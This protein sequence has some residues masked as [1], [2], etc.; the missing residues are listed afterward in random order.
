MYSISS[1]K[2]LL[3]LIFLSLFFVDNYKALSEN[4]LFF[5][6]QPKI[7]SNRKNFIKKSYYELLN[8]KKSDDCLNDLLY[9]NNIKLIAIDIDGT[10]ADDSSKISNENIQA[11][12]IAKKLGINVIFATGR[13]YSTCLNLFEQKQIEQFE[14]D[15][16]DGIYANGAYINLK[17]NY[18]DIR[19]FSDRNID[20]LLFSLSHYNILEYALFS[21]KDDM[22]VYSEDP[23][24]QKHL[25]KK[26]YEGNKNEVKYVKTLYPDHNIVLLNKLNDIFNIGD[27]VKVYLFG[28]LFPEQKHIGDILKIVKDELSPHFSVYMEESNGGFVSIRPLNTSKTLAIDTYTRLH[29]IKL[30]EV[31]SIA[32]GENDVDLLSVTGYSVSVKNAVSNAYKAA[33]CA[34][35]KT[36]NEH[37]I[38]DIIYKVI[39]GRR[40]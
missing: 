27:I 23:N 29:N 3:C 25:I 31:L 28:K 21:N 24:I 10:L 13:L 7:R 19:K 22:Y 4:S 32:N 39:S 6:L 2:F 1:I 11:M 17:G 33:K 40:L 9:K 30:D 5:F 35:T 8:Y 15:K 16:Y 38:A 18:L 26:E 34:S 37:A 20:T 12:H 36:N 14:L